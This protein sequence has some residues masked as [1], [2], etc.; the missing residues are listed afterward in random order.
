MGSL[1]YYTLF[2]FIGTVASDN[3]EY[4]SYFETILS[5]SVYNK[6]YSDM[7]T[8]ATQTLEYMVRLRNCH[9]T[10]G[11]FCVQTLPDIKGNAIIIKAF[12]FCGY[13]FIPPL[14]KRIY[15]NWRM[16]VP[17]RFGLKIIIHKIHLPLSYR[18]KV[19]RIKL[20]YLAN[21]KIYCGKVSLHSMSLSSSIARV[22]YE[23]LITD[24]AVQVL[25]S[26]SILKK[27][28][29]VTTLCPTVITKYSFLASKMASGFTGRMY[30]KYNIIIVG[31]SLQYIKVTSLLTKQGI[32]SVDL[33]DGP[34]S[35]SPLIS[36]KTTSFALFV[37]A[38][39]KE[40]VGNISGFIRYKYVFHEITHSQNS[41]N[42]FPRPRILTKK[43]AEE[44]RHLQVDAWH[45]DHNSNTVCVWAFSSLLNEP[46][47]KLHIEKFAFHGPQT[48][49]PAFQSCYSGGIFVYK[50]SLD[51]QYENCMYAAG[52]FG[53]SFS[54]MK[55]VW[56]SCQQEEDVILYNLLENHTSLY[57]ALLLVV[58]WFTH[59][60]T[61]TLSAR[62]V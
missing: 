26:Y 49:S 16:E 15:S 37:S 46:N 20:E 61:G 14:N 43:T 51:C 5:I 47:E 31:H 24:E 33:H 19:A 44:N 34:S 41:A 57:K 50:Y 52:D 22:S 2:V 55:L 9:K 7:L 45:Q 54:N 25:I 23:N 36:E 59:L 1:V 40:H 32:M 13:M 30:F 11:C 10:D 6:L 17:E 28:D 18:C 27:T 3:T 56:K 8:S 35:S 48:I 42:C 21:E 53:N 38:S 58:V 39:S 29:G 62:Y 60:S 4:L 12:L